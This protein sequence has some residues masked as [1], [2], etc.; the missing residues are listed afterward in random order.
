MAT[1]VNYKGLGY[2]D[3]GIIPSLGQVLSRTQIQLEGWRIVVSGMSSI[4]G[5]EFIKEWIKLP[6]ELRCSLHIPRDKNSI[7]HLNLIAEAG[8]QEWVW[9]GVGLNTK[10]IEDEALKLGYKN[11]LI[12]VAFG[13]VP[14][15]NLTINRI[16]SKFPDSVQICT[17]SISTQEGAAALDRAGVDVFRVGIGTSSSICS[18]SR[19]AGVFLG[20]ATEILNVYQYTEGTERVVLADGGA[21]TSADY[22]KAFLLGA[23]YV[24]GGYCFT[25]CK[26]AQ[27]HIDG[28][29]EYYG[30]SNPIK[31]LGTKSEFNESFVRKQDKNQKLF[32]LY[33]LLMIIWSGIRSGVSYSG[34]S[35]VSEAIGKGEF[36]ELK[37]SLPVAYDFWEQQ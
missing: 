15:L 25:K 29:H 6:R 13:G 1:I 36:V 8:L 4:I 30:M 17:G 2:N 34:Y 22:A 16:K 14:Q 11:I 26:S 21:M 37:T 9:V 28:S 10:E 31:G 32:S 20:I 7:K 12:D 27:M 24:M 33:D 3:I 18:T 23:D 35:S 19:V 5:E